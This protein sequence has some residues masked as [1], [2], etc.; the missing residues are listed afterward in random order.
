MKDHMDVHTLN[1]S[2]GL[3]NTNTKC[4]IVTM[5]FVKIHESCDW[6]ILSKLVQ[7]KNKAAVSSE[8]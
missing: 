5:P 8:S 3:E 6:I 1:P 7:S 4:T 2:K